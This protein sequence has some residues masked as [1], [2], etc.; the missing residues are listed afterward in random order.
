MSNRRGVTPLMT[1]EIRPL[2]AES[3]LLWERYWGP[4]NSAA[5]QFNAALRNAENILGTIIL[6]KEGLDPEKYLVDVEK[7]RIV[8][9]P[10]NSGVN[11]G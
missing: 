5:V 8:P 3:K 6:E 4:M 10:R 11:G 9:R 7:M 2:S 1:G